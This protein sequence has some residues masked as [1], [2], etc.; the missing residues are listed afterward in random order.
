M[1]LPCSAVTAVE[2]FALGGG[3]ELATVGDHCIASVDA[4]V[5]FL[6][7]KLGVSTG[8][9]GG[10]RLLQRM[11]AR[12][13]LAMLQSARVYAAPDA[14]ELGLIDQVARPGETVGAA[15]ALVDEWMG[16][17]DS[18]VCR[19]AKRAVGRAVITPADWSHLD[20]EAEAFL[21]VWGRAAH[22]RALGMLECD[23]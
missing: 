3:A 16:G 12:K 23:E 21:S 2:R 10:H 14:A 17:K 4:K 20:G 13:A 18:A 5:G 11:G 15:V 1:Y 9:G 19:A 8:W 6:Q 7:T 22:R